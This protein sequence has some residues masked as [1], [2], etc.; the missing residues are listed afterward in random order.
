MWSYCAFTYSCL[1]HK[2][3]LQT[4]YIRDNCAEYALLLSFVSSPRESCERTT[5][6]RS[7]GLSP[8]VTPSHPPLGQWLWCTDA[9]CVTTFSVFP[10]SPKAI[11]R[12]VLGRAK[13]QVAFIARSTICAILLPNANRWRFT[14]AGLHRIFTCFPLGSCRGDL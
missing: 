10:A 8:V 6:G 1:R 13:A 11:F 5:Y 14:A 9:P 2:T 7:S 12:L 4:I 3:T